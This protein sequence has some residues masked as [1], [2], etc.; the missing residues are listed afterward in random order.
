MAAETGRVDATITGCDAAQPVNNSPP[1]TAQNELLLDRRGSGFLEAVGSAELLAESL[2]ATGGVDE[3]LLAGEK[4]MAGRANIDIDLRLGA[5]GDEFISTGALYR[6][7]DVA[8][9]DFFFHGRSPKDQRALTATAAT[10]AN[11]DVKQPAK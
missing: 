9:M 2:D 3:L 11:R 7:L 6:A 1:R 4:R 10:S 8:G 5:A